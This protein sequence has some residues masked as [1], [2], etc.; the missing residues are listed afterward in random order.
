MKL[1]P[2]LLTAAA[3]AMFAGSASAQVAYISSVTSGAQTLTGAATWDDSTTANW[4]NAQGGSTYN[5][6][7]TWT[8]AGTTI[9]GFTSLT[10]NSTITVSGNKTATGLEVF[11]NTVGGF[12]VFFA[13][14]SSTTLTVNGNIENKAT[15]T[16]GVR[17]I[18]FNSTSLLLRGDY[19]LVNAVG[20]SI[21]KLSS[22]AAGAVGGNMTLNSLTQYGPSGTPDSGLKLNMNGGSIDMGAAN[23]FATG[24]IAEL[25]GSSTAS[26]ISVTT[27]SAR[28]FRVN[29]T[30]NTTYAGSFTNTGAGLGWTIQKESTGTL[31]LTGDNSGMSKG[32]TAYTTA[33]INGGALVGG[34]NAAF[35]TSTLANVTV[36][37]SGTIGVANQAN[38]GINNLALSNG[39]KFVFDLSGATSTNDTQ[40]AVGGTWTLGTT[41]SYTIDLLGTTGLANGKYTLITSVNATGATNWITGTGWGAN[42]LSYDPTTS[43]WT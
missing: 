7:N 40:L 8:N 2:I 42:T 32:A 26:V 37:A 43:I 34:H 5:T 24:G 41:K 39:A 20:T 22:S 14:G 33:T 10:A 35:G 13:A 38:L 28:T 19:S 29:Q 23:T 30:G 27:T 12:Q 15:T 3:A 4:A 36:G 16:T 9:A 11:K 6:W 21:L 25:K 18:N 31:T 17:T 1:K